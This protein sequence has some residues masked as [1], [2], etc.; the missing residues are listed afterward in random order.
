METSLLSLF[1]SVRRLVLQTCRNFI[2]YLFT[3]PPLLCNKERKN[4]TLAYAWQSSTSVVF[5]ENVRSRIFSSNEE[6][7][8]VIRYGH[9]NFCDPTVFS[10]KN[11]R[12]RHIIVHLFI[13]NDFVRSRVFCQFWIEQ[14][15]KRPSG[16]THI[17]A[18]ADSLRRISF[19]L[20]KHTLFTFTCGIRCSC[21]CL[22]KKKRSL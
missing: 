12:R 5:L 6:N 16:F 4:T 11:C 9:P 19:H 20:R 18:R 8:P 22:S 1:S 2:F 3:P 10:E 17:Y 14:K 21:I 7:I 13:E 15:C